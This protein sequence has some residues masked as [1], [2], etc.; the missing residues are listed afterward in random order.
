MPNSHVPWKIQQ[1]LLC[2]DNFSAKTVSLAGVDFAPRSTSSNS[3]RILSSMLKN[4]KTVV[5]VLNNRRV[6]IC[7][8]SRNDPAHSSKLSLG[9][10]RKFDGVE[11]VK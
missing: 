11:V 4:W 6:R 10:Q 8:Y 1:L 2:S 5:D 9:E 7:K 3:A